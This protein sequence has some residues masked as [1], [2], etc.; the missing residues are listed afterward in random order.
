LLIVTKVS[1]TTVWLIPHIKTIRWHYNIGG[2][3]SVLT[4]I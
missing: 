3:R 1:Q 2:T 4:C